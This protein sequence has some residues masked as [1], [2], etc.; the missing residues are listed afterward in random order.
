MLLPNE[1]ESDPKSPEPEEG[2]NGVNSGSQN[3]II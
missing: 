1:D 2:G 3:E